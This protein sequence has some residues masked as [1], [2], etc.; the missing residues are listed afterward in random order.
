MGQAEERTEGDGQAE[1][2]G[3]EGDGPAG[4][5]EIETQG[6]SRVLQLRARPPGDQVVRGDVRKGT[7]FDGVNSIRPAAYTPQ[8]RRTSER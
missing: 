5:T 6:L 1:N 3:D 4:G 7:L 8:K 2:P